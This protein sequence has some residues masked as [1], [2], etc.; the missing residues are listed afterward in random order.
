MLNRTASAA[1]TMLRTPVGQ[2][3]WKTSAT[4][5]Q[6]IHDT[7]R[8]SHPFSIDLALARL[9]ATHQ[10]ASKFGGGNALIKRPGYRPDWVG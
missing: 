10:F 5:E 2:H 8:V 3:R 9:R 1:I 6:P 7:R 4:I